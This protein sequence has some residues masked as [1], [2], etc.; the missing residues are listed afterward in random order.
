MTESAG[1]AIAPAARDLAGRRAPG[2]RAVPGGAGARLC[3]GQHPRRLGDHRRDGDRRA[4]RA[5]LLE[6][7]R[8]QASGRR[9]RAARRR[10]RGSRAAAFGPA[11]APADQRVFRLPGG[12]PPARPPGPDGRA[13][14]AGTSA[15]PSRRWTRRK[16][17]SSPRPPPR[18]RTRRCAR[19][20]ARWA[21]RCGC[22]GAIA[23]P[24]PRKRLSPHP[25]TARSRP[26]P[27]PD[28]RTSHLLGSG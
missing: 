11:A 3:R 13:A 5:H 18:S 25:A 8:R 22:V 19:R 10:R 7:C 23:A 24:R 27:G 15:A 16:R 12:G 6:L 17:R 9:A 26:A 14:S 20:S 1:K 4:L 28:G 2:W 21:A